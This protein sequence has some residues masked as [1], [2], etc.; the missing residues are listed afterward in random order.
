MFV[1]NDNQYFNRPGPR[2]VASGEIL[3][4]LLHSDAFDFGHQGS[5]WVQWR[6]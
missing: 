1:T 3:A 2:L 4:E 5:G 6:E